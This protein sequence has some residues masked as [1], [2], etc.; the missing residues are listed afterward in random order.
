M[1]GFHSLIIFININEQ[2]ITLSTG[3][4]FSLNAKLSFN[5]TILWYATLDSSDTTS[6]QTTLLFDSIERMDWPMGLITKFAIIGWDGG[7]LQNYVI[8]GPFY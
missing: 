6:L 1:A 8:K 2:C 7:L 3:K 5:D 4:Y